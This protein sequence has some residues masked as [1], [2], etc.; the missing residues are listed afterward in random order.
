MTI[1]EKGHIILG[2]TFIFMFIF[3]IIGYLLGIINEV[4]FFVAP[5]LFILGLI[6]IMSFIANKYNF[7][8]L[9]SATITFMAIIGIT[10]LYIVAYNIKQIGIK[11]YFLSIG[12]KTGIM[13]QAIILALI[14]V[15]VFSKRNKKDIDTSPKTNRGTIIKGLFLFVFISLIAVLFITALTL[16][17]NRYFNIK[18]SPATAGGITDIVVIGFV[19]IAISRKK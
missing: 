12:D 13:M 9:K 10:L 16:T 11:A 1:E 19:I 4:A 3:T 5:I 15:A 6:L 17:L 14:S 8:K 7:T 2:A 18:I